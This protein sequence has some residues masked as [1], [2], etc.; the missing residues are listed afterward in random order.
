MIGHGRI[1]CTRD[2]REC[3][4]ATNK[5]EVRN[6]SDLT[7]AK[8]LLM[9]WVQKRPARHRTGRPRSWL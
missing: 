6:L 2:T 4:D 3:T 7:G 1:H 9:C 5:W 8:G